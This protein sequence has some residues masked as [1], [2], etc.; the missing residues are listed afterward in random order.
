MNKLIKEELEKQG[1]RIVGKHSAI[2]VCLW[3]KKA[4]KEED[5]CYKN[6]FYN[7]KPWR[8]IQSSVSLNHCNL[9][10]NF[11]WRDLR[12][13]V[14]EEIKNPDKPKFI[15]DNFIKEHIK[16]L[17]GFGG[18]TK[19]NKK[20]F[21]EAKK[22]KHV[23][24]SLTGETCLYP[25]LPEMIKEIHSRGMTSFVVTNGTKPEMLKKLI[26]SKPTQTYITV[27]APDKKNYIKSCNPLEKDSWEKLNESL[28][29]LPELNRPTIRLTLAKNLNMINPKGYAELLKDIDFKFLELKAFMTVGYAQ[30]RV[31]YSSMP[32]HKEIKDFAKI[33]CRENKLKIIDEKENS[34]VVL[35]MKKDTKDRKLNP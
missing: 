24:L 19:T 9:K 8:C 11:C 22:P 13:T 4:I 7:I 16:Y 1:Y 23:A 35:V 28:K 15:L 5:V 31:P 25:K 32:F 21:E 20:R 10:C 3:C 17:Q 14:N 18:N 33:I 30:Y 12:H 29:I 26:K 2:K 34:R 6:T 27:A